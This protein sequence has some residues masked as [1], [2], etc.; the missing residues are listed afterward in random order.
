[1]TSPPD[2]EAPTITVPLTSGLGN[3]L[4]NI[5]CLA[6]LVERTGQRIAP[7]WRRTPHFGGR[8]ADLLETFPTGVLPFAIQD[9]DTMAHTPSRIGWPVELIR[10]HLGGLFGRDVNQWELLRALDDDLASAPF[11][12]RCVELFSLFRPSTPLAARIER[13]QRDHFRPTMIGV[14]LRRGDFLRVNPL[15]AANEAE[16]IR[17]IDAHLA[18]DAEAGILLVTDDGAIDP[19]TGEARAGG[20]RERLLNRYGSRLVMPARHSVDRATSAAAEDAV[21]DL[22]LL[23]NVDRFIGTAWSTFS[24]MAALGRRIP[25]T[26]CV[27]TAADLPPSA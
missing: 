12:A 25:T 18:V 20:V 5:A 22:W 19:D 21:V 15:G 17:E 6:T 7:A 8:F 13:F 14:H 23:R 24:A 27:G 3:R 4:W 2:A 10:K 11:R 1:M 9:P 26:M 16:A